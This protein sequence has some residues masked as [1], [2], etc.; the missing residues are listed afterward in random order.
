MRTA[1]SDIYCRATEV[2][3]WLIAG[4][5][6]FSASS[7]LMPLICS[8]AEDYSEVLFNRI[9]GTLSMIQLQLS[10]SSLNRL[11]G[12]N[13]QFR[14]CCFSLLNTSFIGYSVTAANSNGG[15]FSGTLSGGTVDISNA[16]EPTTFSKC[17]TPPHG[18]NGGRGGAA[19]LTISTYDSFKLPNVQFRSIASWLR[20]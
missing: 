3:I 1:C 8:N 20:E 2:R 10:P 4:T 11:S 19:Y 16:D 6:M 18:Q 15:A 9:I 12:Q 7:L 14:M 17:P 13:S 5:Q